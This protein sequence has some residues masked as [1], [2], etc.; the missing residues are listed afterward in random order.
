MNFISRLRTRFL[1]D[2]PFILMTF[3][4]LAILVYLNQPAEETITFNRP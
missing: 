1:N 4:F 3:A 2:L